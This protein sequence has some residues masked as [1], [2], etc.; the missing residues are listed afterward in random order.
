MD[1]V[2]YDRLNVNENEALAQHP[3]WMTECHY[4]YHL[5]R[6]ENGQLAF[7]RDTDGEPLCSPRSVGGRSC[8][9][10]AMS[11]TSL[12]GRDS[13]YVVEQLCRKIRKKGINLSFLI[14]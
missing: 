7:H 6:G 5:D 3:P 14:V 4:V 2:D 8:S 10:A 12:R 9:A 13:V 1:D 11:R